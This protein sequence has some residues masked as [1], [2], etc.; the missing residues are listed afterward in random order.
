MNTRPQAGTR[1]VRMEG[2]RPRGGWAGQGPPSPR[3]GPTPVA[4]LTLVMLSEPQTIVT[5][6][7]QGPEA[8]LE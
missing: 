3:S 1:R 5:G 2:R 8:Q 7:A 4:S 6:A